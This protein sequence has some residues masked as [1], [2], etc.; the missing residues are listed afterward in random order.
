MAAWVQGGDG[1]DSIFANGRGGDRIYGQAGDDLLVSV[2]GGTDTVSGGTGS[3]S[4]WAD[5]VDILSDVE[6]GETALNAVHRID[7]FYQPYSDSSGSD[8][9]VSTDCDGADLRDPTVT[10]YAAGYDDFSDRPL[11][12]NGPNVED[13]NQGAVGDCYF[14]ASLASLAQTDPAVMEQMITEL[15]DGTYAVRFHR[16][17]EEVYLRVDGELPVKSSGYLAYAKLSADSEVWVAL[18]EKAYAYFRYGENSYSSI[19]GGWMST[20]YRELTNDNTG[21]KWTSSSS[22]TTMLN[23]IQLHMDA[24][25]AITAGSTYSASGPIVGGHAYTIAAVDAEADGGP[26]VTLYNPWGIDGRTHDDQPGDGYLEVGIDV[27]MD[28]YTA[29]VVSLT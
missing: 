8:D 16:G 2:G 27:L 6:S 14:L 25:H 23:Y 3:D 12:V 13:I 7:T 20:V 18:A 26:T 9:Y 1:D 17:G 24:G 15:G 22:A 19:S 21:M 29:V 5:T 4:F 10:S 11:F 28:N